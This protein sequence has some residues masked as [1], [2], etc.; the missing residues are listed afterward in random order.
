MRNNMANFLIIMACLVLPTA[1]TAYPGD[2]AIH[3]MGMTEGRS[4]GGG[5]PGCGMDGHGG[6][7]MAGFEQFRG[8]DLTPDQQSKLNKIKLELRKQEWALQGKNI[9]NTAL[10][11]DL[12]A[13][14][15]PDPKK[16]GQTY[17]AIFDIR[18]QMIESQI[19]AMN[20]A[21]DILNKDQT[22]KLKQLRQ[23]GDSCGGTH[24][25]EMMHEMMKEG[26]TKTQ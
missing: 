22:E 16:I 8:L 10:L 18:R 24:N 20:R 1:A 14:D 23:Q 26:A 7:G 9:D 5:M 25:H 12:Y 13:A 15:R 3:G 6:S 21:R 17:S 2:H 4:P 11:N 19:V